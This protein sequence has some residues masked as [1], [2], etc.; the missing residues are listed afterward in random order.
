MSKKIERNEPCPCGS[1][2]K[3]KKCCGRNEGI[4]FSLPEDLKTRT[5]VDDYLTLFQG[6]VIYSKAFIQ[7]DKD[8]KEFKNAADDFEKRFR[9][10]KNKGLPSSLFMS[11]L[12][13][14]FRFGEERETICERFLK[15]P[16]IDR[17]NEPG[18]TLVKHLAN[19]YCTFY[20]VK[21][22]LDDWIIF[23]EL[24]T[25]KEWRVYRVNEPFERKA[26]RGDIWYLRFVG[27]PEEG[28]IYTMPY[29]FPPRSKSDFV[30]ALK[31]QKDVFL[32]HYDEEG[33]SDEDIFKESCKASTRFWA[34]Y[35]LKGSGI[36]LPESGEEAIETPHI[37]ELQNTD[38][39]PLRFCKVFFKIKQRERLEEKLSSV[40]NFDFD[41]HNKTWI[42]FKKGNR[43]I[44]MFPTTTL[45]TISIVGEYLVAETNSLPRA[46]KLK[47]KL[48]RGFKQ[49]LSYEKI[50]SKDLASMP[51]L[52]KEDMERFEK[53]QK[54]LY[55]N[56]EVR[57][58]L[59]Q[60]AKDYYHNDWMKQKIPAL[61]YKTPTQ[62]VKT[63]EGRR[64]VEA[65]LNDL[66]RTQKSMPEEPFKVDVG[67]L[68]RRL[69]LPVKK[70]Q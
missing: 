54:E 12:S 6:I 31:R 21:A 26:R 29:I 60:K 41:R 9:P 5:P 38:G 19:S 20:E 33:L 49:S 8:G 45:G 63:K 55:S 39:E 1:G 36:D 16:Y 53:E 56:P 65:L 2:K 7:F 15:S 52:S 68:R 70:E 51:P 61:D 67:G 43:K 17:L 23:E 3:Y 32:K 64:K 4:D 66:E 34:E 11:W 58:F 27:V 48:S 59:S 18:P 14:D 25:G 42:W 50:E 24:G 46:L 13:L 40:K 10:G 57:E 44:K 62:A 35:M 69:G 30:K 22:P 37:P 47:N 28:Y